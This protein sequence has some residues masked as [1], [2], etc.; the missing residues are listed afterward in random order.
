MSDLDRQSQGL[1]R[2]PALILVDMIKGF[3]DPAC[4]LGS[5]ADDVVEANRKLLV[6]RRPFPATESSSE[7]LANVNRLG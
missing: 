1:G 7:R 4:P 3:T 5:E 2:K 6:P